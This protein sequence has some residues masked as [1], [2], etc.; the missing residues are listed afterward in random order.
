MKING[1]GNLFN[2]LMEAGN[3]QQ[4]VA[5]EAGKASPR[6]QKDVSGIMDAVN[7]GLEKADNSQ[8]EAK[9]AAIAEKLE[10]GT[11]EVDTYQVAEAMLGTVNL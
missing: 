2:R 6:E 4:E 10:N 11:Y 7:Q 8:R 5:Q 1:Y 3:K 9:V